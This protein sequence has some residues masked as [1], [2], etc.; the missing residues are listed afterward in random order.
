ML[1]NNAVELAYF[2]HINFQDGAAR[3]GVR[4]GKQNNPLN[5]V[6]VKTM[7]VSS[8]DGGHTDLGVMM[9]AGRGGRGRGFDTNVLRV[10]DGAIPGE[11]LQPGVSF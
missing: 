5:I 9:T 3:K 2:Q 1:T 8:I 7:H 6:I 4:S 11:P 10:V